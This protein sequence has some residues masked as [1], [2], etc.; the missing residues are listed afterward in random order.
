MDKYLI[1]AIVFALCILM[2]IYTQMGSRLGASGKKTLKQQVQAAF[3]Q[4]TVIEKH[5]T[6]IICEM[7]QRQQPEELVVIRV[8]PNQKKNVRQFG[9]RVT[10]TYAKQPSIREIKKDVAAYL[11]PGR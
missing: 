4:Y 7:N 6:I 9:K 5:D 1:V 10:I 11:P 2:I 3:S 8:D